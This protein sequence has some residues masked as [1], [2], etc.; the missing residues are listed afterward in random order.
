[1]NKKFNGFDVSLDDDGEERIFVNFDKNGKNGG[2][3][4]IK[5]EGDGVAIEVFSG[6]GD[7]IGNLDAH[8][9]DL[10]PTEHSHEDARL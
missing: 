1:M 10:E 4:Y 8:W 5:L 2:Y 7:V 9:E 3:I 6:E